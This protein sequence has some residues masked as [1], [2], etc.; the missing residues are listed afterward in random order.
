MKEYLTYEDQRNKDHKYLYSS[1]LKAAFGNVAV[2]GHH[3]CFNTTD[4]ELNEIPSADCMM[5]DHDVMKRVFPDTYLDVMT[6]LA[7]SPVETRDAL[8]QLF[9]DKR[10]ETKIERVQYDY[11]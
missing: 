4:D 3:L 6:Q 9:F 1:I 10:D 2:I 5:F 7:L 11:A 8:L